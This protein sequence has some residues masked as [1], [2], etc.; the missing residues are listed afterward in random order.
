MSNSQPGA[1]KQEAPS[2][3][4]WAA[5]VDLQR[6]H[7]AEIRVI[8]TGYT[9]LT[10]QMAEIT[11]TLH[12]QDRRIAENA[13][14]LAGIASSVDTNTKMTGDA[15]TMLADVRDAVTTAT[16]LSKAAKWAAGAVIT[17]AA[18][19]LSIKDLFGVK[20]P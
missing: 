12:A 5:L 10:Q 2:H 3:S 11:V 20:T 1:H 17:G 18:V 16:V 13:Q 19:W 4:D 9:H 8:K 15:L 7:A 14:Q 6:E